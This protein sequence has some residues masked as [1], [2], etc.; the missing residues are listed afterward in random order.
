MT[1]LRSTEIWV[2]DA[3]GQVPGRFANQE[4]ESDEDS[5]IDDDDRDEDGDG[6]GDGD[7]DEHGDG[8]GD[9]YDDGE[10]YYDEDDDVVDV[11]DVEGSA[12]I[13]YGQ[14]DPGSSEPQDEEEENNDM[15]SGT[16]QDDVEDYD[17]WE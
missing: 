17:E 11:A 16:G 4:P 8:D 7:G 6:D 12:S 1:R 5:V 13:R 14:D 2:H 9:Q 10:Q 3:Q 15:D